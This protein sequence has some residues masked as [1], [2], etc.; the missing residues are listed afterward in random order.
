MDIPIIMSPQFDD[1]NN[2][3][4]LNNIGKIGSIVP[5]LVP[6]GLSLNHQRDDIIIKLKRNIPCTLYY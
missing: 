2:D 4:D 5:P 3:V 6:T 1:A